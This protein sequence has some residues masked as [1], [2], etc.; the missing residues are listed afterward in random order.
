MDKNAIFNTT[1]TF[2]GNKEVDTC[3]LKYKIPKQV[4]E[5][6]ARFDYSKYSRQIAD[7]FP[8][9]G[10]WDIGPLARWLHRLSIRWTN[11]GLVQYLRQHKQ[12][13]AIT[14]IAAKGFFKFSLF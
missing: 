11:S 2:T 7:T 14:R 8:A 3:L 4:L 6:Q 12:D 10:Y 1:W 5:R 13:S 9:I